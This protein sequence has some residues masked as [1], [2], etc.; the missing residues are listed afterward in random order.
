MSNFPC[1]AAAP[2]GSASPSAGGQGGGRRT[3]LTVSLLIL[4]AA[5]A[6]GSG[7][8][9]WAGLGYVGGVPVGPGLLPGWG[10]KS[11]RGFGRL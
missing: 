7:A 9:G 6:V 3:H 10:N 2:G 8:P 1:P 4:P 11:G 5:A